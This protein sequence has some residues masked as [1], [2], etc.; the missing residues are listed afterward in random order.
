[1]FESDKVIT[2]AAYLLFY[3]RRSSKPLGGPEY[4]RILTAADG[5]PEDS[6]EETAGSSRD[7]SPARA[8]GG[9]PSDD[10]SISI[11][12]NGEPR[13]SSGGGVS[14][15]STVY[16]GEAVGNAN[17]WGKGPS[18]AT[19]VDDDQPPVYS[20]EDDESA[21]VVSLVDT[22]LHTPVGFA[23][24]TRAEPKNKLLDM[25]GSDADGEIGGG[26]I[27]PVNEEDTELAEIRIS[28][29]D[30]ITPAADNEEI[31]GTVL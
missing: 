2:P 10:S 23:F 25:S 5:T 7:S 13:R 1:M 31:G 9:G 17:L 29:E 24:G 19:V 21:V 14:G 26:I 20:A 4:E 11:T 30:T 18:M 28:D 12:V 3:R 22:V 6:T 27:I 16:G 15:L 8:G